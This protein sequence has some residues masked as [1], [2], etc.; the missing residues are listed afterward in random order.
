MTFFLQIIKNHKNMMWNTKGKNNH[1][2]EGPLVPF[3]GGHGTGWG[4]SENIAQI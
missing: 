2:G 4:G 3:G 1:K